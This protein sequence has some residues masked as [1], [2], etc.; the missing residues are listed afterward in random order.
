MNFS[1]VINNLILVIVITSIF[2]TSCSTVGNLSVSQSEFISMDSFLEEHEYP[3]FETS[4]PDFYYRGSDWNEKSL[5]LIEQAKES[6]LISTFLGVTDD[7]TKKVWDAL[8]KKAASGV[9]VYISI[10]SASNFQAI[11]ETNDYVQSAFVYLKELNLNYVEYNSMSLSNIFFLFSLLDRDHRKYWIIDQELVAVGGININHTS[12][13]YPVGVGHIDIMGLVSS[14]DL[15]AHLTEIFVDTYNRYAAKEISIKDFPPI[16]DNAKNKNLGHSAFV[17]NHNI[18]KGGAVKDLFDVFALATED[19]LWMV[20]GYTFLSPA[21]IKRIQY[22]VDKGVKVNFILS[23]NSSQA[24]YTKASYYSMVDLLEAGA[25]VYLY[26]SPEK[27]FLHQKVIVA[28]GR[29]SSFGSANYN[30]RS[31]TFSRE[32][33]LV[34]DDEEVASSLMSFIESLLEDSIKVD[35]EEAKEYR[36]FSYYLTN[37]IMQVWG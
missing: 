24:K 35:L 7:F 21:L 30:F 9:K 31:H 1:K 15:A 6:I 14:P 26:D 33:N 2:L 12:L 10:D 32:L 23:D 25:H 29:Y 20:Q 16:G 22:I 27:A 11:P 18:Q 5:E 34:Y 37:L 19:E 13:N 28:D 17:L 36:S 4:I 3:S 8:A